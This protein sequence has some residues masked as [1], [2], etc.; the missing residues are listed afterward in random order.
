M[1]GQIFLI[2]FTFTLPFLIS[3]YQNILY[4]LMFIDNFDKMKK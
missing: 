4:L 2:S 1:R 3:I